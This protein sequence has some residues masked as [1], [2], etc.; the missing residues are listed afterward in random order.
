[1]M[2]SL[3]C[4]SSMRGLPLIVMLVL[5]NNS[6]FAHLCHDP[7][8]PQE[9]LVLVPE[10]TLISIEGT[11][12]FRIYIENTF[13][14]ILRE[15]KLFVESPAFEIEIEPSILERLE[16]G[17]RRFFLIKLK[18]KEGTRPKDYPLRISVD[19]KSAELRPSIEKI[20][21]T[22]LEKVTEEPKPP[23]EPS[24]PVGIEQKEILPPIEKPQPAVEEIKPQE[25][26]VEPTQKEIA[27]AP[28]EV[29]EVVVRVEKAPFWKKPYFYIILVLL[30]LGILIWRKVR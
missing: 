29:G 12:E 1:M 25:R 10:K 26:V 27:P 14:S 16:P 20:D 3:P 17:E 15:I 21:V 9:H 5:I 24:T 18:T 6:S 30:L 8:R 11:G 19:A 28:Q 13:G 23:V 2:K 4:T 7:F 22:V